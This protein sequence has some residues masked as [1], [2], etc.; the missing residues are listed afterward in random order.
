MFEIAARL[1]RSERLE[2]VSQELGDLAIRIPALERLTVGGTCVR[3]ETRRPFRTRS[4][5]SLSSSSRLVSSAIPQNRDGAVA[6]A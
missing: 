1:H 3:R 2:I 5:R 4:P 6:S